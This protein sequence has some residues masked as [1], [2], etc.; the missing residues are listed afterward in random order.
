[1]GQSPVSTL[2]TVRKGPEGVNLLAKPLVNNL[3]ILLTSLG[4]IKCCF[5]GREKLRSVRALNTVGRKWAAYSVERSMARR[6]VVTCSDN[7]GAR[8]SKLGNEIY[9]NLRRGG[10]ICDPKAATER[11]I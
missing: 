3:Y 6:V 8:S 1:V 5:N 7:F 4:R 11:S 10:T 9:D 2:F